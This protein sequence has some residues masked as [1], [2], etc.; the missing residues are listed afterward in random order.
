[1]WPRHSTSLVEAY[2]T[3]GLRGEALHVAAVLGHNY[4][5]SRWYERSYALLDDGQRKKILD[6]RGVVER[7]LDSLLK[8]D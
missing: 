6:E 7:T 1:M 2:M 5:G 8:P 3:L 4:P